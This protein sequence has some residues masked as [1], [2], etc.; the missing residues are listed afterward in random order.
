M[1]IE[2]LLFINLLFQNISG[3]L[4]NENNIFIN[5]QLTSDF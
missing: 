2:Q 3:I 1:K 5:T 4:K